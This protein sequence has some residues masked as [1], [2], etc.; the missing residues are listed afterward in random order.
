MIVE[1]RFD[2]AAPLDRVWPVLKDVPRVGACI[3]GATRPEAVDDRTYRAD[4]TVKAGPVT[5]RYR[6]TIVVEG[7]DDATHEAVLAVDAREMSGRGGVKAT[8]TSRA[9]ANG[10]GTHVD[11]RTDAQISGIVA[12]VGGRLI[13][14]IASRT[15]AAFAENLSRDVLGTA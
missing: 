10:E 1:N 14:G 9:S 8:V 11:L 5:V 6:A 2:I 7:I 15:V 3:P 12:T 13:E 4:V